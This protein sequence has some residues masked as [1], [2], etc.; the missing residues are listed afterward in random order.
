MAIARGSLTVIDYTDS[1]TYI[2]YA[3]TDEGVGVETIY[4]PSL[5]LEYIGFYNGPSLGVSQPGKEDFPSDPVTAWGSHWSGWIKYVGPAG[6]SCYEEVYYARSN[7]GE[8]PPVILNDGSNN[9]PF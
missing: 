3:K 4:D 2:Y 6:T 8:H 5:G 1:A 7:S 9:E